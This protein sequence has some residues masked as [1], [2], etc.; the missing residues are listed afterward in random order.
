MSKLS[1]FNKMKTNFKKEKFISYIKEIIVVTIGVLIALI[2]GSFK[3]TNQAR[4]YHNASIET[5]NTEIETNYSNLKNVIEKHT[6]LLDTIHKYCDAP[7]TISDLI[8]ESG[9]GL[10]IATLTNSG[11]E[12]Y[13]KNQINLIDFNMISLLLSNK[14][15]SD[16]IDTKTEKLIDF[17]YPNLF[18]TSEESKKL[19]VLYLKNVL[20]SELQLIN[21]Y[22]NFIDEHISEEQD[23][24]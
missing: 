7:K 6:A 19:V 24:Q 17:I 16:L 18:A 2:V 4:I 10:Q 21:H 14:S 15:L 23:T 12:I 22:D 3:E 8:L 13:K 1:L 20:N 5:I 11:L 9:G